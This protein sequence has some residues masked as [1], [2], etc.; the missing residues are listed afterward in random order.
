MTLIVNNLIYLPFQR[1]ID[2]KIILFIDTNRILT[3]Q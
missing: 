1:L 2:N 3:K